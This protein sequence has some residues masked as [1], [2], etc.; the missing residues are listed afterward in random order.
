MHQQDR[1]LSCQLRPMLPPA[2]KEI[3]EPQ[4]SK[5]VSFAEHSE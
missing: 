4:G 1:L 3:T 2:W 5:W